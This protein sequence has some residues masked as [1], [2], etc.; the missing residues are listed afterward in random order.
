MQ[1][2]PGR[3]PVG[4]IFFPHM[5]SRIAFDT[6][7]H[8]CILLFDLGARSRAGNNKTRG[9]RND[10]RR[11]FIQPGSPKRIQNENPRRFER[12]IWPGF[13]RRCG[14]LHRA[15]AHLLGRS[16]WFPQS[17]CMACI[18]GLQ[19]AGVF[20]DVDIHPR[21]TTNRTSRGAPDR[22]RTYASQPD[23]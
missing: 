17:P 3:W 18:S 7:T 10:Q 11:T 4:C 9:E 14:F 13:H 22:R 1:P 8:R 2:F 21:A 16:G 12:I 23:A 19:A 20:E 6:T 5:Q 15:C